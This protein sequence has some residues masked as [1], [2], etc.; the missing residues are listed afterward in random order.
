[1]EAVLGAALFARS[2]LLD[3]VGPLDGDYFFFLEETDWCE[4]VRRAGWRVVYLP[5]AEVV[6]LLGVAS[7]KRA[8]LATRIE[9]CRSRYTFFRKNRSRVS[10]RLLEA[11]VLLKSS[12]GSFGGSR[13][14]TYRSLI[15]W[16]FEGRPA[17][18]GLSGGSR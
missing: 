1:V 15:R 10:L 11:W 12:L 6:H 4:R 16:H 18:A 17:S 5:D 7:K 3:R 9:F 14:S 8:P 2:E 13:A